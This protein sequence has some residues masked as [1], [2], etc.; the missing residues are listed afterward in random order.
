MT[1]HTIVA[2]DSVDCTASLSHRSHRRR[3]R[4]SREPQR[5]LVGEMVIALDAGGP[6]GTTHRLESRSARSHTYRAAGPT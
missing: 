3:Q 1:N 5:Q 6:M 2:R 4:A